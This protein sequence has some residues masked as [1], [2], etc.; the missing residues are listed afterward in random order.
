MSL[1]AEYTP[2]NS[3]VDGVVFVLMDLAQALRL[4][5]KYTIQCLALVQLLRIMW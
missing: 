4:L 3:V 1:I 2:L 5:K